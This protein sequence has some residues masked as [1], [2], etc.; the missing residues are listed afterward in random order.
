[1][2]MGIGTPKSQSKI[3]RP[4]SNSPIDVLVP[5]NHQYGLKFRPCTSRH[6]PLPYSNSLLLRTQ[7]QCLAFLSEA[8]LR[9]S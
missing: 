2:M 1:M 6:Q 7:R 9:R 3:E 8:N 4:M 5:E